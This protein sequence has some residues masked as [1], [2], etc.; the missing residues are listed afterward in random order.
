MVNEKTHDGK[1]NEMRNVTFNESLILFKN[2]LYREGKSMSTQTAYMKDI[3]HFN[4]FL[5]ERLNNKIRYMNKV[6]LTEIMAYKDFLL[7]QVESGKYKRTTIDRMYNA[8]KSYRKFLEEEYGI[9]NIVKSDKFGNRKHKTAGDAG[10][11]PKYLSYEECLEIVEHIDS[12]QTKNKYRDKVIFLVL[13][14]LGARRSE[15]LNLKWSDVDLYNNTITI[16]RFKTKNADELPMSSELKTSLLKYL[17]THQ[18][19]GTHVFRTR[20]SQSMSVSAFST[21]VKKWG[22]T[23]GMKNRKGFE[24]TPHIFRHSFITRCVKNNIEAEKIIRYTGHSSKD[25]IEIYTHLSTVNLMDVE[26]LFSV[27]SKTA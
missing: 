10:D 15:V 8:F 5:K 19:F 23:S 27:Q 18:K 26:A 16:R 25:S 4:T 24:I 20:E 17:E 3:K 9:E 14:T 1:A 13:I 11:L 21:V 6:T 7:E 22:D 2:H 12:S